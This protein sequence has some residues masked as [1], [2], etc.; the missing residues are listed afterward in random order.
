MAYEGMPPEVNTARSARRASANSPGP[1]SDQ[2]PEPAVPCTR[3]VT[4]VDVD[5]DGNVV[6]ER[7]TVDGDHRRA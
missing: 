6:K 5:D 4:I 2:A 3:G 7:I 1:A